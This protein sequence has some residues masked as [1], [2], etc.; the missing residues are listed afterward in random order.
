MKCGFTNRAFDILQIIHF[1][2]DLNLFEFSLS[3]AYQ[4][5]DDKDFL[6]AD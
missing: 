2:T 5:L 3:F 1:S 4:Y 6:S